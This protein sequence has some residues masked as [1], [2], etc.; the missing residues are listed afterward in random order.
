MTWI[1][2]LL[3]VVTGTFFVTNALD[4]EFPSINHDVG[5]HTYLG[6]EMSRGARLYV[7]LKEDNPPGSPLLL[8]A[9][10]FVGE[11]LGVPDF[12]AQ[13]HPIQPKSTSCG[14]FLTP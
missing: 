9:L 12:A 5:Y 10:F 11:S 14:R 1:V 13:H 3:L 2:G 7:D 4:A 8:G 6:M